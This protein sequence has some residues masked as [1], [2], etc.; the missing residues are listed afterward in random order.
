M[1]LASHHV[2]NGL[3]ERPDV[4]GEFP[5]VNR[6]AVD[7]CAAIFQGFHEVVAGLAVF[8]D[9]DSQARNGA[10]GVERGDDVSPGVRLGH[11]HVHAGFPLITQDGER[12]RPADHD[13][14]GLEGIEES[15][16]GEGGLDF[17]EQV[18]G[19][20]PG[21]ENHHVELAG[22]EPAGELGGQRVV[23]ER[24]FAERGGLDGLAALFPDQFGHRPRK[25][26]LEGHHAEANKRAGDRVGH[27]NGS[28]G[29]LFARSR[30]R[31]SRPS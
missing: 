15:L 12:L 24:D 22:N 16:A 13:L 31:R 10:P 18:A 19:T 21:E 3:T 29:Q 17:L 25:A 2:V 20:D 8:L 6:D 11:L 4:F 26:I 30:S 23:A 1:D 28:D 7:G 5:A 9:G 14:H 27:G